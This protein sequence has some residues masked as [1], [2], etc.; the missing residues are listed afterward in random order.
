[1]RPF[2]KKPVKIADLRKMILNRAGDKMRCI[3]GARP[4]F[5]NHKKNFE[6]YYILCSNC[7]RIYDAKQMIADADYEYYG[8]KAPKKGRMLL[9]ISSTGRAGAFEALGWGFKSLIR[10][11]IFL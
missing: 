5:L 8:K 4:W 3:C 7:G 9:R 1:M 2:A 11:Q 6:P 10:N